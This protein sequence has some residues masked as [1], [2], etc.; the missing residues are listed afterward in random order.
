MNQSVH[1]HLEKLEAT[2]RALLADLQEL[3][4][5]RLS[6]RPRPDKW[7][8]L[9]IV[10][11]LVLA[12]RAILQEMPDATAL[13]ARPR[14]VAHHVK[15]WVVLAVLRFSIPVKVPAPGMHPR[16]RSTLAELAQQWDANSQW[17]HAYAASQDAHGLRLAVFTHPIA[18]PL[19]LPQTLRTAAYHVAVHAAQIR[20]ICDQSA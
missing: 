1:H 13:V 4:P 5:A 8:I 17:L 16:G 11:H 3:P 19:T 7:S 12:E 14:T 15:Y 9:E 18:G 6:A 20:R 10:E 2:R